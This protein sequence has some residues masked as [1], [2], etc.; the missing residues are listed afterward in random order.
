MSLKGFLS[1]IL[2]LLCLDSVQWRVD[3]KILGGER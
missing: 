2:G 1:Y 3:K